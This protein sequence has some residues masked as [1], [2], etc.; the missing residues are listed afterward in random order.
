MIETPDNHF[1]FNS[2]YGAIFLVKEKQNLF[3]AAFPFL[4][5]GWTIYLYFLL[6]LSLSFPCPTS[7]FFECVE[8]KASCS[9]W[10]GSVC[11]PEGSSFFL[12]GVR[13]VREQFFGFFF[14][15]FS[16]CFHHVHMGFPKL[17]PIAPHF[18]P[19]WFAQSLTPMYIKWKGGPLGNTFFLI[20][21]LGVQRG[22][23][24]GECPMFRE[25]WWW[26]NQCCFLRKEKKVWAHP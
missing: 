26:G 8:I 24:I 16:I 21:G 2:L 17:F 9:Q 19:L 7:F 15:L 10:E 20:L 4:W 6:K 18:Y 22:A 14:P 23:S 11:T 1:T 12:C 3:Q 5:D 25:N 13:W